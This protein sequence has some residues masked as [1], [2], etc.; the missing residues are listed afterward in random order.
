MRIAQVSPL[1]ESVPPAL[2]GG[3]ERVVSYLTEELVRQGHEVALFASGDSRTTAE[4]VPC[5]ELALRLDER[6]L[7]P[8]SLHLI[9]MEEVL[10]R[11]GEFDIIHSHVDCIGFVLGRRTAVPVINTLH[12]R[13]DMCEH[14]L[15]FEEY[16]ESPLVSISL[17]Q[18]SARPE[19]NWVAN[20]QH[21]LPREL[22]AFSPKRGGYLLYVGRVSPEKR[23]DSAI[24]IA[25]KAGIRLKIAAKVDHADQDYF[26]SEIKPLLKSRYV[27]FLGEVNDTEKNA[28]LGGALAFLHPVDWPEPFGLSMLEAMA[29]G[30]PVVARRRGS[31]PEVVEQGVTGF[32]FEDD[33]EAVDY[34]SGLCPD[35]SRSRCRQRFEERFLASRMAAD[36]VKAYELLKDGGSGAWLRSAG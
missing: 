2:Y 8:V 16:K 7:D 19:A 31:I 27:E 30:T 10:K 26:N 13:L 12:G 21:G 22:Y 6:Q 32:I 4:L 3:T 34:V 5:S 1:F 25:E 35:F 17:S 11:A 36:Y 15:I 9:M 23:V 20:I 18:R 28:L 29:C 14:A 24:N 33:G